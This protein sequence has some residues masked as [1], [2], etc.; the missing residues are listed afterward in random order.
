MSR[1]GEWGESVS[2]GGRGVLLILATVITT[3]V[4][5]EYEYQRER[6]GTKTGRCGKEEQQQQQWWRRGAGGFWRWWCL[7]FVV[8]R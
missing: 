5:H 1:W 2:V 3:E 8:W 4:R 6:T 7:L